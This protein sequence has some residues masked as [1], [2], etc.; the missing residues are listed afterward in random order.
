MIRERIALYA[1]GEIGKSRESNFSSEER[2]ALDAKG[3]ELRALGPF[4][5][6]GTLRWTNGGDLKGW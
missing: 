4:F 5:R 6:D 1:M 3:G 2:A